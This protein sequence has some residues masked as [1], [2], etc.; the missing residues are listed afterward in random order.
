MNR[1]MFSGVAGLKTHQTKLDVI[2]N[3]IANVNTFGFKSQRAVFS[4]I[5]YQT[6]QGA[7]AGTPNRGGRNPSSVG[8]GSQLSAIQTQM[9][10]SS[11][12]STGFG[13]DVAIT[14]EGFFQVMDPDGNIFYTKAGIFDYDAE[15]YLVDVNGNFVLGSENAS[16]DPD[17]KKIRLNNIGSV[18]E[19]PSSYTTTINTLEYTLK[20]GNNTSKGNM[21]VSIGSSSS[22][23]IGRKVKA[24][25]GGSGTVSIQLNENERFLS[26]NELNNAINDAITEANGGMPHA[27]GNLEL[28]SPAAD[29]KFAA[30]TIIDENGDEVAIGLTGAEICGTNFNRKQGVFTGEDDST[31]PPTSY[32]VSNISFFGTAGIKIMET[33]TD[34]LTN[35]TQFDCEISEFKMEKAANGDITFSMTIDGKEFKTNSAVSVGTSSSSGGIELS[36]V[37]EGSITITNPGYDVLLAALGTADSVDAFDSN[38]PATGINSLDKITVNPATASKDL[39]LSSVSF[40]LSGGTAGGPV[41]LDELTGISIGADGIITVTHS[42]LGTVA[43]GRLSLANF[44][45]PAGLE[46]NGTNYYAASANSGEPQLCDPGTDGTGALKSNSLE[47]SNVDLSAEFADMITTQ[48]GFQANSRIITVSDTML[49]EL[50]NLK[51]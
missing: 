6:L 32:D 34:F 35:A 8:Y 24:T 14:G 39:G 31:T 50:I 29:A 22:L 44:A 41:T 36:C 17:S 49:E 19:A 4:D 16:G 47:M 15:G 7:S 28:V 18:P 20:T 3:N 40:A 43:A 42:D 48:R 9:G 25:I 30:S 23:P 45:N 26:L 33:S 38:A 1:A 51:R 2:G 27:A 46:L 12:Q 21:N 13:M 5:F 10:Q 11:M 37:G